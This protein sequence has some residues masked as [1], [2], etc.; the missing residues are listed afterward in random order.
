MSR[1][2]IEISTTAHAA[3]H[4]ARAG[5]HAIEGLAPADSA[6]C[7]RP[8]PAG[9]YFFSARLRFLLTFRPSF[10]FLPFFSFFLNGIPI[11][12]Y[13]HFLFFSF[14]FFSSSAET[15]CRVS[16]LWPSFLTNK[17]GNHHVIDERLY[18]RPPTPHSLS[19]SIRSWV[20]KNGTRSLISRERGATL[21]FYYYYYI[22]IFK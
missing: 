20:G 19:V 12:L 11:G 9:R 1:C 17:N 14:L 22:R 2:V 18:H 15:I 16:A 10:F 4:P 13:I 21:F 7:S 8:R 6:H 5:S 3:K